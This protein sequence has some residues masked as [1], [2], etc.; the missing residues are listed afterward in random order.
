MSSEHSFCFEHDYLVYSP[1]VLCRVSI[2]FVLI[3]VLANRRNNETDNK[4]INTRTLWLIGIEN[5]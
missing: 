2:L 1:I 3:I 4:S 5:V